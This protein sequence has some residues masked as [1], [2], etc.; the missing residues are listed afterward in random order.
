MIIRREKRLE[1]FSIINNGT[2]EDKNLSAVA[3]GIYTYIMSKPDNWNAHKNEIYKRFEIASIKTS[4]NLID[5]AFSELI[6]A[7]YIVM[8]TKFTLLN[9]G[10]KRLSGKEYVFHDVPQLP[11]DENLPITGNLRG[12]ENTDIGNLRESEKLP[13]IIN[14]DLIIN[15]NNKINTDLNNKENIEDIPLFFEFKQIIELLSEKTSVK[16]RIPKK[17]SDLKKYKPYTLIK[18]LFS[19]KYTLE[20]FQNVIETK[21]NEWIESDMC[22]HLVPDTL[23]RK[24]NFEKY[25]IQSQIKQ[26]FNNNKNN[27][28]GFSNKKTASER[29]NEY[30]KSGLNFEL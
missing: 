16:Y 2:I 30:I 14:T 6:K 7:G 22:K 1:R 19:N 11:K 27:Q 29:L 28:N 4:K 10:Q 12:S 18:E 23:F 21:V 3:L 15:T 5:S 26:K 9:N 8:K 24:S 20:D 25:L 17:A 13:Y